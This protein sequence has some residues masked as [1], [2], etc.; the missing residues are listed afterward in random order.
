MKASKKKRRKRLGETKTAHGEYTG[1]L[2]LTPQTEL[3]DDDFSS[4]LSFLM[5]ET[6]EKTLTGG[7][8][9]HLLDN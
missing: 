4:L 9:V 3:Q 2:Y 5:L 8:N 1:L 6:N 7:Q